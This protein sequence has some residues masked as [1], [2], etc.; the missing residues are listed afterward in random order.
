MI[1]IKPVL[2]SEITT[3]F[4]PPGDQTEYIKT[5]FPFTMYLNANKSLPCINF[6][7]N[8]H[9]AYSA[10]DAFKEILNLYGIDYIRANGLDNYGGCYNLRKSRVSDEMSDHAWAMAIDYLP[11]LGKLG[12]TPEIPGEIVDIF[13][14]RNFIWGGDWDYPDGMHWTAIQR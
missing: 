5:P 10:V 7:G 2:Y 12:E 11:H 1:K 14:K 6:Y 9:I 8:K 13:K 4:G 3:L